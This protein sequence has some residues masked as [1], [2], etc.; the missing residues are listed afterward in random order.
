MK[1]LAIVPA[2]G[3]SKRIP[4][5]NLRYLGSKPLISWSIDTAKD[6]AC[7]CDILVSTDDTE[8]A[9]IARKSGA[10]VP[11]LRPANLATDDASSV[12][13]CIHALDWYENNFGSIDGLLLLQATSPFRSLDRMQAGIELFKKNKKAIIGISLTNT[14]PFLCYKIED[15][16]LVPYIEVNKISRSQDLPPAYVINGSFY[17]ISPKDLRYYETFMPNNSMPLLMREIWESIDIDTEFDLK[18]AEMIVEEMQRK[19]IKFI[20]CHDHLF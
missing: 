15:E 14:H 17:L 10:M 20:K 7:L 13:V 19:K 16:Q 18:I 8:I 1:I 5:K 12:S 3:G 6:L 4:R 2:R 11:W 9:D